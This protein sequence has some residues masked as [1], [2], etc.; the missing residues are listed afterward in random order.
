MGEIEGNFGIS[1][2]CFKTDLMTVMKRQKD[3]AEAN[4]S[5][6]IGYFSNMTNDLS[7]LWK[8]PNV[9]EVLHGFV[10]KGTQ[11]E[12]KIKKLSQASASLGS[13][14]Q[15]L[16]ISKTVS[17]MV[18]FVALL[19]NRNA[20][21]HEELVNVRKILDDNHIVIEKPEEP[22]VIVTG[23]TRSISLVCQPSTGIASTRRFSCKEGE[24]SK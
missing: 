22:A 10:S 17:V 12:S 1:S 9:S 15:E 16:S 24:R 23:K 21:L 13:L 2:L 11:L 14:R 20:D 19:T 7:C 3:I 5:K 4:S 6:E 18:E 8:D